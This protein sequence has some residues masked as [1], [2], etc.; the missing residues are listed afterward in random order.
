MLS[1]SS[2]NIPRVKA[3]CPRGRQTDG[4][5]AW[6]PLQVGLK[7]TSAVATISDDYFSITSLSTNFTTSNYEFAIFRSVIVSRR[8]I[9]KSKTGRILI[10][11]HSI[12]NKLLGPRNLIKL[13]AIPWSMPMLYRCLVAQRRQTATRF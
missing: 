9:F 13:L 10:I 1:L 2:F 12:L 7:Q 3:E 5:I 11:C 4:A 6:L 8:S